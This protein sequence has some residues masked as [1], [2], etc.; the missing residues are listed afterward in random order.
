[1]VALVLAGTYNYPEGFDEAIKKILQECARIPLTIPKDSVN[2]AILPKNW[3][4]HWRHMKGGTSSS[5]S[6]RHFGHY[7]VGLKS[8]YISY[9]QTLH[10]KLV[11]KR[12][13]ILERWAKGLSVML[14]KIFGR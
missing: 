1:M 11:V 4:A 9:L 2:T 7:K 3:E 5:V 14:E 13:L 6:G 12:D 10:A 8:P